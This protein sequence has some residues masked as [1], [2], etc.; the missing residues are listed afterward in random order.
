MSVEIL[1]LKPLLDRK[2]AALS[3][4]QR[5]RVVIG[6]SIVRN[7]GV[8]LFDE[9]L[10]NLDAAHRRLWGQADSCRVLDSQTCRASRRDVEV[11]P[12]APFA[13]RR[14]CC[15]EVVAEHAITVACITTSEMAFA[16]SEVIC[17]I[18][19][20]DWCWFFL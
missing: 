17:T 20:K 11:V 16:R 3:G 6:R 13:P 18:I 14:G 10:S 19:G 9:P 5:Q 8:F 1:H 4:G 12:G 15:D 2:P 7:P